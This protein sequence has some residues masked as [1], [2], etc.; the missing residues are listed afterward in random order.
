MTFALTKAEFRSSAFQNPSLK[1]GLQEVVLTIT[2]ANTDTDLDIG[3]A[4]GTFWT[5]AQADSTYGAMA[6]AVLAKLQ[7]AVAGS[8]YCAGILCPE[9]QLGAYARVASSPAANQYALSIDTYGPDIALHSGD[10]PTSYHVHVFYE[11]AAG[12]FPVTAA[13]NQ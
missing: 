12:Q 8:S 5:A 11:M 3:D 4:S 7:A 10:A 9:L 1:R 2:A 6:A 13:F